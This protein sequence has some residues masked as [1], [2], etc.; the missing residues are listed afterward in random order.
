V[1]SDAWR[2]TSRVDH[3]AVDLNADMAVAAQVVMHL[4]GLV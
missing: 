1:K 2:P 4:D 3:N